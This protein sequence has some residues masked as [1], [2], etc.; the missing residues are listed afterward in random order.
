VPVRT[1]LHPGP[2]SADYGTR[3]RANW[4][5]VDW[6]SHTRRVTVAGRE[7]EVV[8]IGSGDA[9][10]FVHGLGV[11][12]QCWLENI[13]FFARTHRVIALDLPG[14]GRS[15]MPAQPISIE[16]YGA[17]L[18]E[19]CEELGVARA[20]VVGNSLGGFVGAEMAIRRPER[21]ERLVLV[22][23]AVLWQEYRRA[24]PLIALA[25]TAEASFARA[26]VWPTPALLRRPRLRT[27]ALG[28]AGIRYPHLLAPEL[29]V[30]LLRT[31]VR[32]PG[33]VPALTALAG[34]PLREELSRIACPTLVVWGA[35]DTLVGVGHAGELAR[36]I[37]N[38]TKVI[39]ERTGHMP[40][41]ER[42]ER[43]NRAVEQF[44]SRTAA[45]ASPL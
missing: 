34:Y 36:S 19:L 24:R 42:P 45:V 38:A 12:W 14:F 29:Q 39:F 5:T 2:D 13:P 9:I 8:D 37:P 33:F 10:V 23:A 7:V 20:T 17:L 44:I 31:A 1:L 25:Q 21:V 43:F 27:A 26:V 30:E 15:E 28:L 32:T 35:H 18:D 6:P 16:R 41:I 4:L 22:S 3:G 40:M 11:C